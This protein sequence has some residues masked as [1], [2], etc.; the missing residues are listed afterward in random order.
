MSFSSL[1]SQITKDKKLQD[2]I[3]PISKSLPT[4]SNETKNKLIKQ[5]TNKPSLKTSSN[6]STTSYSSDNDPAVSRLKEAR[7]LEREK[8]QAL[9]DAKSKRTIKSKNNS[10]STSS[11]SSSN[12]KRSS[13][14]PSDRRLKSSSSLPIE[15]KEN[16][17]LGPTP[18]PKSRFKF[19]PQRQS[20][21]SN[22]PI[23]KNS[24]SSFG[25]PNSSNTPKLSFRDLMKQAENIDKS[26][27]AVI[28]P[29]KSNIKPNVK[30]PS[31]A[32]QSIQRA[33]IREQSPINKPLNLNHSK[34]KSIIS[35]NNINIQQK[36]KRLPSFA[37]PNPE[38]LNKLAKKKQYTS[39]SD[40][41]LRRAGRTGFEYQQKS[42]QNKDKDKDTYDID[43]KDE[44]DDEENFGYG[45]EDEYD[46]DSQDDDFI[47]D[48]DELNAFN[49]R[50]KREKQYDDMR[51]QGYSRD[52]I[53]EIFNRGKK[54]ALYNDA[55][56]SDDMEATGTEILEDEERTLKQAKLDDLREQKLLEKRALQKKKLFRK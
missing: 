33:R 53:W 22:T 20:L 55:Y 18:P 29:F 42:K 34:N 8:L 23:L 16:V 30:E 13:N 44:D 7:R 32:Y 3:K 40:K 36:S 17:N 54:R 39:Q 56:D 2:K 5:S 6:S 38:L 45:Y 1:L 50:K 52:E 37:K 41:K 24:Q 4:N 10:T 47:V 27:T 46:Y 31:K 51:S 25:L 12:L 28:A 15:K 49:S 9:K 43:A 26:S 48:D 35:Q 14:L 11:L 19:K 21:N